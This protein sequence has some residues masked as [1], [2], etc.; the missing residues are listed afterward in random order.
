[1]NSYLAKVRIGMVAIM[2]VPALLLAQSNNLTLK[3]I[4]PNGGESLVVDQQTT[5]SWRAQIG[6]AE[7]AVMSSPGKWGGASADR[8]LLAPYVL[9]APV[10]IDLVRQS[11]PNYSYRIATANLYDSKFIWMIPENI[12]NGYDYRIRVSTTG[13]VDESDG[14]F[15]IQSNDLCYLSREAVQRIKERLRQMEVAVN[16][17]Q[18]Q[19]NQ[20]R[21]ALNEL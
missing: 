8:S 14:M 18:A 5:I 12:P 9:Y 16:Q 7:P 17:L 6:Y 15:A 20:L 19:I 2:L 4:T 10:N 21:S 1:M 13:S 11:D 3:L